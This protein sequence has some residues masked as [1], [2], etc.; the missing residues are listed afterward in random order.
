MKLL[1][2]LVLACGVSQNVLAW[3]D[4]APCTQ[5]EIKNILLNDYLKENTA[6]IDR[7]LEL[8]IGAEG[9][10]SVD[11]GD[12]SQAG[13]PVIVFARYTKSGVE[14]RLGLFY[15]FGDGCRLISRKSFD[16][17]HLK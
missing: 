9:Y 2:G 17:I 6:K 12:T 7:L 14:K 16:I 13:M 1:L 11:D 3:D 5:A 4:A 8:K 10:M 15:V